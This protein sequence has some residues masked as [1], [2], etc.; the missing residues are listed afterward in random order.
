M[1]YD[2]I[3]IGAGLAGLM[4]AE[5]ALSLGARVLL[6]A[7]GIGSLPLATGCI[8]LL[9]YAS[10]GSLNFLA[11]PLSG[12]NELPA[13]HPY[14]HIELEEIKAALAHF[15]SIM[16][17]E[18]YPYK[19]SAEANILMPTAIGTPHPAC[20]VP[21]TFEKGNLVIPGSVL[22]LGFEGFKDFSAGFAAGN[23][24]RQFQKK[25]GVTFRSALIKRPDLGGKTVNALTL[26]Q[27]FDKKDFR[28]DFAK[29]ALAILS[30]GERLGLPA[31]LGARPSA[32]I[33][34]DLQQRIGT[35][36]FE[37]A[38]P[39]PS[40]PGL[41]LHNLLAARLRKKGGRHFIGFLE[42]T[43]RIEKSRIVG[44][45]LGDPKKNTA[46]RASAF[47]LAT[48][49]FIGGGLDSERN[50]IFETFFNLPVRYPENRQEWFDPT[51][52]T[53]KG[54]P[55]N[56]FGVEVDQNLQPVDLQGRVVYENL[57][58]AGGIIAHGNAVTEK[59][60][61][62]IAVSTGYVAGKRA[63]ALAKKN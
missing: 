9:G 59:S 2:V 63:A 14:R 46:Y 56:G 42:L 27:A 33:W 49:Q 18:N 22:L 41:R 43:P 47:I 13:H 25:A 10:G 12:L 51:L 35:G 4:A 31:V 24:N 57:F 29:E 60:G 6:L 16:E 37:I 34:R 45:I 7:K 11:S 58:A 40:V 20:L 26:A 61:G 48:G 17:S 8:D 53:L 44:L 3:V 39:P 54:Q 15:Q 50:R 28:E 38:L 30:P 23:L 55:F 32:E 62:G 36:I 52:L 1:F 21:E 19:G 5:S